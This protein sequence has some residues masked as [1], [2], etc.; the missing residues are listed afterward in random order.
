[1][2]PPAPRSQIIANINMDMV[3]RPKGDTVY[4]TG[5]G[6]RRIG[7]LA[8]RAIRLVA[9][10]DLI[11]LGDAALEKRYPGEKADERSDHANFRH[12]GIPPIS[13]FTGWHDDYHETTDDA[14]KLDYPALTRIAGL[15][16]DITLEIAGR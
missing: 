15:V 16:R 10:R 9:D 12:R 14:D 13:I 4:V 8:N 3:G 7:P 11:I 6:D 2:R 1:M 5:T